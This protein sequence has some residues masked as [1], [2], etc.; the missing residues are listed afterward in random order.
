MCRV[1]QRGRAVEMH[2]VI[3]L[4]TLTVQE[5]PKFQAISDNEW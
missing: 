1:F 2:P 3:I 4:S 5:G